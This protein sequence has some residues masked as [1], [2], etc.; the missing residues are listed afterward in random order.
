LG[1]SDNF[2]ATETEENYFT[3]E[4]HKENFLYLLNV[5]PLT[6]SVFCNNGCPFL[7]SSKAAAS[8]A[9]KRRAPTY[10]YV[11]NNFHLTLP[12]VTDGVV[13]N[14]LISGDMITAG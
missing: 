6:I 3:Q 2:K 7:R 13:A 14:I 8:C 12:V 9:T 11:L 1:T 5:Y 10:L 4:T